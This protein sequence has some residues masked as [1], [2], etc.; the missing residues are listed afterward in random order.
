MKRRYWI[1][2]ALLLPVLL[3]GQTFTVINSD[4]SE[5]PYN[6]LYCIDF[7]NNGNIWFGGQD[8][9]ATGLAQVSMLSRDGSA[10]TVYEAQTA[11][12]GLDALED[13]AF[14]M[15]FD[16]QNT[17]W[18]ATHYG[19]SY[20]KADGTAG[21]V[22]FTR[23]KYTRTVQTDSK[24]NIYISMREDDRV[25]SRLHVSSDHGENWTQW[26][27][28][29]MG[30]SL[31]ENDARPEAYDIGEDSMGQLWVCTWY[32]VSYRDMAGVWH[33]IGDLENAYTLG[34][35][36]DP[37]DNVW[38]ADNGEVLLHSIVDG[39]VTTLDSTDIEPL[40]Y[41]VL[42]LEAD[43]TG[44]VWCALDGGG[45]LQIKPDGSWV[46][47]TMASTNGDLPSDNLVELE[48]HCGV[49]WIATAD[50]GV[51]RLVSLIG[52][53][54]AVGETTDVPQS[55]ALKANYPNPFN[56]V[57][58]IGYEVKAAGDVE[59]TVYDIRGRLVKV[60]EQGQVTAGSHQV[61]WD[62][63]NQNGDTVPS[64]VYI[65][66]LRT[67]NQVFSRKMMLLK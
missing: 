21:V 6:A 50:A 67:G 22:E 33:V 15:A 42:D 4:N 43:C 47:H 9:A 12:L 59:L 18:I 41:A 48:I 5:L 39:A 7:D 52:S 37:D 11:D 20:K 60:L 58:A 64:G 17:L 51:A 27:M 49:I 3:M 35:T 45:L 8:D 28:A 66:R 13:R 30:F 31:D 54:T 63:T 25:N 40:K 24:G 19:I 10:W 2:A 55:Y 61:L 29:D 36:I 46:Q 26:S 16:D 38:V 44:N 56:P 14:Y 53:T 57:T 65:Y 23:D 1:L 62:A 32:G 34:M